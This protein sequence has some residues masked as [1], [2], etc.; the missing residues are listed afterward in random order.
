MPL[1][2]ICAAVPILELAAYAGYAFVAAC[3]SL[4]VQLITGA[5][6]CART[7]CSVAAAACRSTYDSRLMPCSA[8]HQQLVTTGRFLL[9]RLQATVRR[10]TQCG[11]TA[12]FAAL[13]SWCVLLVHALPVGKGWDF[14]EAAWAAKP[15]VHRSMH[16]AARPSPALLKSVAS[17]THPAGAHDE[18]GDL[19]GG[20]H[21]Q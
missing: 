12:R 5:Q 13:S 3:A 1:P 4:A 17:A 6:Q 18:A 11:P 15:A 20:T 21:L 2:P 10:T 16:C 14:I 9:L 7:R 19:P 8:A